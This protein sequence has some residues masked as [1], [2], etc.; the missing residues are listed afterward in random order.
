VRN[1]GKRHR[2]GLVLSELILTAALSHS[3]TQDQSKLT[4][5]QQQRNTNLNWRQRHKRRSN[6]LQTIHTKQWNF[7][8]I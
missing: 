6:Y 2:F 3:K 4:L 1:G 8:F 7:S 5:A